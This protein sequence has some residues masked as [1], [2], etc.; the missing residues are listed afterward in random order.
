MRL[1]SWQVHRS[2]LKAVCALRNAMAHDQFV[3]HFSV[4]SKWIAP[5]EAS[6]SVVIFFIAITRKEK[7]IA[8]AGGAVRYRRRL[9]AARADR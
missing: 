3:G 7:S 9:C 4:R 1:A 2:H 8:P 5:L 6:M